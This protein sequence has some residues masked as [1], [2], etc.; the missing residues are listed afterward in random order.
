MREKLRRPERSLGEGVPA[1][2]L[3]GEL[4]PL[5]VDGED[6]G[7]VADHVA[8]AQR[9]HADF[10]FRPGADHPFATVADIGRVVPVARGAHLFG[11]PHRGAGGGV[12]LLVVVH[13]D[14]FDVVVRPEG[15]RGLPHQFEQ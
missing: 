5:A 13:F 1:G 10:M 14:D 15:A 8:A 9:M 11:E 2:R 4:N 12:L 6:D 7:V 3:V